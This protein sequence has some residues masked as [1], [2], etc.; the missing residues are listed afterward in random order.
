MNS[1]SA[2][3][4]HWL[5]FLVK[6]FKRLLREVVHTCPNV[7]DTGLKFYAVPSLP[8]SNVEFKV[9]DFGNIYVKVFW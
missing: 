4:W 3:I 7:I 8:V 2:L 1:A 6:A 5:M 9:T